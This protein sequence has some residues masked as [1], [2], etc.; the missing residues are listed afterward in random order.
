[1]KKGVV[2]LSV[3][4][5]LSMYLVGFLYAENITLPR[6]PPSPVVESSN[7]VI[8]LSPNASV[9]TT[10]SVNAPTIP[11]ANDT[12]T[13]FQLTTPVLISI[14]VIVLIIIAVVAYFVFMKFA[15]K[16]QEDMKNKKLKYQKI[17]AKKFD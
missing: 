16:E 11:L 6:P 3:A 8:Q 4:L 17:G 13:S 1:M 5:I 9:R 7:Q 10:T 14:F 2:I 12:I 15:A